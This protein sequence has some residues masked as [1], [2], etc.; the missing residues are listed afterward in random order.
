MALD[1][2]DSIDHIVIAVPARDEADTIVRCLDSLRRATERLLDASAGLLRRTHPVATI[3]VACDGCSD[4]TDEL[5]ARCVAA[6]R[7]EELPLIDVQA[8]AG[9]WSS[10]GAARRAAVRHGLALRPSSTPLH[11]VWIATTDAD[12]Y[13]PED[14][15][16]CQLRYAVEGADAVAG[17]VELIEPT[18]L[19]DRAFRRIYSLVPGRD[20]A[21]VHGANLG[22]R[23]DA[24]VAAGGFPALAVAEDHALWNQLRRDGRR[25]LSPLDVVVRTSARPV[26]RAPGGFA[27]TLA[28]AVEGE[29]VG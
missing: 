9:S 18:A 14:W 26:G 23:A 15:L 27:D 19:A 17:I 28:A 12:S 21:H 10:A 1:P 4:G 16:T 24:Y 13:V 22:V 20:H 6:A 29:K 11:G 7:S 2:L 3:A 25:C 8:I 5:V